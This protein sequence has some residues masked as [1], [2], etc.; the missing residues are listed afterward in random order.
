MVRALALRPWLR[1]PRLKTRS[2]PSLNLI[3]V[4]PV[5]DATS[6]LHL[7]IANRFASGHLGFLIVVVALGPVVK[8]PI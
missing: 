7:L 1:D 5:S 2:K 3:L 6:R 8:S 4:V